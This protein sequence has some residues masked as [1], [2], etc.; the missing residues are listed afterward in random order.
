MIH[1][2]YPRAPVL[3]RRRFP[4]FFRCCCCREDEQVEAERE[5]E[6][7]RISIENLRRLGLEHRG[8]FPQNNN[9]RL[10]MTWNPLQSM[11]AEDRREFLQNMLVSRKIVK[12]SGDDDGTSSIDDKSVT[13]KSTL[14]LAD[15]MDEK[16]TTKVVSVEPCSIC[17]TDYSEGE[18]LCWSQNSQCQHCFHRDCAMEW[19]MSH[20][21]CPLC[22]SNYLSLDGDDDDE[23]LNRE[24]PSSRSS[25]RRSRRSHT[26]NHSGPADGTIR[27]QEEASSLF[28]GMHLFYILN[29]LQTLAETQP[30]ATIRLEGIELSAGRRGNVEIHQPG[31]DEDE[32][33]PLDR[34][35]SIRMPPVDEELIESAPV[36]EESP[37]AHDDDGDDPP[38]SSPSVEP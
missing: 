32:A 3:C 9:S 7:I 22:R 35:L 17:L 36:D 8:N 11:S 16:S 24:L 30:N 2:C 37:V 29:Q 18:I 23:D 20:E 27:S 15:L 13:R 19:L 34:A 4:R 33:T 26:G 1:S 10:M 14:L 12:V 21:E 28:R 5:A 31:A 6:I 38:D 25:R